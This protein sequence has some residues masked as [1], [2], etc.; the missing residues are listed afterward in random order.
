MFDLPKKTVVNKIIPKNTFYRKIA[1]SNYIKDEF[2]NLIEKIVWKYKLSEETI[3]IK[4]SGNFNEIQIFNINLK[5]KKLPKKVLTFIIKSIPYP[6]LFQINYNEDKCYALALYNNEINLEKLYISDWNEELN[7]S[8]TA[9]NLENLYKKMLKK[10][11]VEFN[12]NERFEE[13]VQKNNLYEEL[14]SDIIK[15]NNQIKQEKQFNR[16]LILNK[17]L[18]RKKKELEVLING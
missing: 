12:S 18:N 15:L 9:L 3:G 11:I 7:F 17:E 5:D 10:F 14:N 13:T 6:V 4:K 2:V 16:K 8:F 1:I